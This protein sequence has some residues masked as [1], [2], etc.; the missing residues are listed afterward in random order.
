MS[1]LGVSSVERRAYLDEIIW[2]YLDIAGKSLSVIWDEHIITYKLKK[3]ALPAY[4]QIPAK[5]P[6]HFFWR[7]SKEQ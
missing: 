6:I 2:T 7:L 3:N 1:Y 5:S 4:Q